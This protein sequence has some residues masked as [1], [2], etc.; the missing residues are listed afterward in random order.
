VAVAQIGG[1]ELHP[2]NCAPFAY[3]TRGMIL[4]GAVGLAWGW[5]NEA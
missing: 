5:E 4:S 3:D 2:W 1:L